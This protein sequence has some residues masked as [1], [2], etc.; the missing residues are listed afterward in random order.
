MKRS[1]CG[2]FLPGGSWASRRE[3]LLYH[4]WAEDDLFLLSLD[5]GTDRPLPI[6]DSGTAGVHEHT[7]RLITSKEQEPSKQECTEFLTMTLTG[8][9][10]RP[11]I[12]AYSTP[13]SLPP[14]LVDIAADLA[15][16]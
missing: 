4:E 3:L 8:E 1:H 5:D 6:R 11:F 2:V 14:R 7:R 13:G 9:E 16:P 12:R 10:P 15:L